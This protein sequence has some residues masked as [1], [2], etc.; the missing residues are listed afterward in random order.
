M[1]LVT[2]GKECACMDLEIILQDLQRL[3]SSAM[4]MFVTT[5]TIYVSGSFIL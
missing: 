4:S 3:L 5:A 2:S 1:L